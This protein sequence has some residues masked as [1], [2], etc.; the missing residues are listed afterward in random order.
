MKGVT[1]RVVAMLMAFGTASAAQS[2]PPLP[3]TTRDAIRQLK[4]YYFARDFTGGE[5]FGRTLPARLVRDP[6]TRAWLLVNAA[7]ASGW[8]AARIAIDSFAKAQPGSPWPV[9]AR[10]YVLA[11][12]SD[13]GD[14]AI[15]LAKR[16]RAV[17]PKSP[18]AI[19]LHGYALQNAGKFPEVVS[20]VDSALTRMAPWAELYDLKGNALA[21]SPD[22][23]APGQ[24][25]AA[26]AVA[27]GLDSMNVNAYY[28]P[29]A[30]LRWDKGDTTVWNLMRRAVALSPYSVE[31]RADYWPLLRGQSAQT[32]AQK[33]SL[34]RAEIDQLLAGRPHSPATLWLAAEAHKDF[35]HWQDRSAMERRI[36][37]DYP[38]SLEAE[39]VLSGRIDLLND[40]ILKKRVADTARAFADIRRMRAAYVARPNH[41]DRNEYSHSLLLF[42][43]EAKDD[44]TI[45]TDSL[46]K[47]G[48]LLIAV[49]RINPQQT[50]LA[51]PM[52]MAERHAHYRWA[53]Q[54]VQAGDTMRRAELSQMKEYYQKNRNVGG[55][56]SQL[57]HTIG[58]THDA[59]GWI[60][61]NEG[62]LADAERELTKAAELIKSNAQMYYH[63]GRLAEAKS[64]LQQA[65]RMYSRGYPLDG[66][67]A[68]KKN[69]E[70]LTRLYANNTGSM[71]GFDAYV[72]R[73]K[74]DDRVRRRA[75]IVAK[76]L[77]AN[78]TM[79]AFSLARYGGS[80]TPTTNKDLAGKVVVMNFWGTWCGP[81]VA[82][83]TQIQKFYQAT[84]GDTTLAFVTV[85]FNDDLETIKG[86]MEREK[87]DFPVLLDKGDFVKTIAKI[88]AYPT[89]LFFGREGKLAF[90]H[91]GASEFVFDEFMARVEILSAPPVATP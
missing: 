48:D 79:P 81:C 11:W 65:Q 41:R 37:S 5:E 71:A 32:T 34:A 44:S 78:E 15:A 24:A 10:A 90:Q 40:S 59:L 8:P 20:M 72:E 50:H 55:Y 62:R 74:E 86:F 76:R 43:V 1:M 33:D 22:S 26:F 53:E 6:E 58:A 17:L 36:L 67:F 30:N 83:V 82:E 42:V 87:L 46:K 75:E 47:L 31:I 39:R 88:N 51:L 13:S 9:V 45:S 60:Y 89:T 49:N 19:W 12:Q 29:A 4:H 38:E 66:R 64:D 27:R 7:R 3:R 70:A 35:E 28:F 18:D 14:K 25:R 91:V 69:T 61:L 16:V 52:A 80:A 54:L 73:L 21:S 63:L 68:G 23:T 2:S 56:A 77:T 85:D 84:K 57:D